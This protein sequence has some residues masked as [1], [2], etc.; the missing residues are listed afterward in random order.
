MASRNSAT[1]VARSPTSARALRKR[2][3]VS[4]L[5]VSATTSPASTASPGAGRMR[6]SVPLPVATASTMVPPWFTRIPCDG[7]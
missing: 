5:A 1:A 4:K 6:V 2:S 7:T 3:A